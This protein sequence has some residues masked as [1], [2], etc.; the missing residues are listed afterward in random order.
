M[1]NCYTFRVQD[2]GV[3]T[4]DFSLLSGWASSFFTF[5]LFALILPLFWLSLLVSSQL[6]GYS[7]QGVI[8]LCV[9]VLDFCLFN[10]FLHKL[11]LHFQLGSIGFG[12][13]ALGG[14]DRLTPLNILFDVVCF[15][16]NL[17]L[18]VVDLLQHRAQLPELLIIYIAQLGVG[19]L[20]LPQCLDLSLNLPVLL[21]QIMHFVNIA[22][23]AIVE[24]LQLFFFIGALVVPI[25]H[26][27][28]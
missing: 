11:V 4:L 25:D 9:L 26:S 23:K 27:L 17:R 5:Y 18:I 6:F 21:L 10:D 14:G 12:F 22:G 20:F 7:S 15:K 8:R 16:L 19:R 3:L 24:P 2:L 13:G 1:L 28:A